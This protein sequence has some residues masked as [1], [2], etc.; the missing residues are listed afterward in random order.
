[1]IAPATPRTASSSFSSSS[2]SSSPSTDF[3]KPR[4]SSPASYKCAMRRC[5]TRPGRLPPPAPDVKTPAAWGRAA[6]S[7]TAL[8]AQRSRRCRGC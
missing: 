8:A 2:P 3:V 4:S 5:A 1:M 7:L 6:T